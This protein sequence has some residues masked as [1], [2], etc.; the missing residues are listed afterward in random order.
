MF[1][2]AVNMLLT[3][4]PLSIMVSLPAPADTASTSSTADKAPRNAPSWAAP[5]TP[6]S[7][8]ILRK[9]KNP[10][11]AFTPMTL[12][13][14]RGFE[15]TACMSMPLTERAEPA[16]MAANTLGRRT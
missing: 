10:A 12:G 3:A 4:T 13:A 6:G 2:P 15:S 5:L 14:A 16:S 7:R 1:M 9:V 11:P 8:A